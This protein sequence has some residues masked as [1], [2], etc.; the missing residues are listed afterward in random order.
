MLFLTLMACKNEEQEKGKTAEVSSV[1]FKTETL[2]LSTRT[3]EL[4]YSGTV[5]AWKTFPLSFQRSGNVEAIYVEEGDAVKKN[6]LLASLDSQDAEQTLAMA[7]TKR[8]QA[9]DAYARMKQ[10][11]DKGSLAEIKWVDIQT[12]LNQA[13]S[14]EKL[15]QSN[16]NKCGLYSPVHGFIGQR[17]IEV[18]MSGL[19]IEAPFKVVQIKKVLIKVAVPENEIGKI[20]KNQEARIVVG[21]LN[22]QRF[23]AKV[24]YIGI[25]A[26]QFSRT[27]SVKLE[28]NNPDFALKPGMVCDVAINAGQQPEVL[29]LPFKA[30]STNEK[31]EP[32]VYLWRGNKA[33]MQLVSLGNYRGD[34]IEIRK[35]VKAG[36]CVI[37]DGK[38]KLLG[39]DLV[40]YS[41][42]DQLTRGY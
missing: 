35:G 42:N 2:K 27:Y 19:E 3:Q 22:N 23:E 28:V 10:L 34:R 8:K 25:V 30:V 1:K 14:A 37:L 4:K 36:D 16:L 40:D 9:E 21:A 24:K 5:E 33:V 11:F 13:Q 41:L 38:E 20:R 17:K 29:S 18:G 6:Q 39:N 12:K 7:T 32:F 31:G 15:A 26:N